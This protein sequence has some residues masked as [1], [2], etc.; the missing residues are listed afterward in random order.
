[1]T[2][3][4]EMDVEGSELR[5][6]RSADLYD[7]EAHFRSTSTVV[8]GCTFVRAMNIYTSELQQDLMLQS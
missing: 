8:A 3:A 4:I 2:R 5:F 1:M 7:H 6:R